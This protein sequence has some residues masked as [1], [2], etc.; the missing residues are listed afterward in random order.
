MARQVTSE[1][2]RASRSTYF[3]LFA[4]GIS[5]FFRSPTLF[6]SAM[7]VNDRDLPEKYRDSPALLPEAREKTAQSGPAPSREVPP[8]PPEEQKRK[9]EERGHTCGGDARR[10]RACRRPPASH[11]RRTPAR[12]LPLRK[13]QN[14]S[15]LRRGEV[16][17]GRKKPEAGRWNGGG[18][19]GGSP[20]YTYHSEDKNARGNRRVLPPTPAPRESWPHLGPHRP[21]PPTGSLSVRRLSASI[22]QNCCRGQSVDP[23]GGPQAGRQASLCKDTYPQR[24]RRRPLLIQYR[25]ERKREGCQVD[26]KSERER[27]MPRGS[28]TSSID[29]QRIRNRALFALFRPP[30]PRFCGKAGPRSSMGQLARVSAIM[31]TDGCSR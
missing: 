8:P 5:G 15:C 6:A 31:G 20:L 10:G 16:A 11:R 22:D 30:P 19:G 18:G 23:Q 2:I 3:L 26:R 14:L 21:P 1:R 24:S 17:D 29:V 12:V 27:E 7:L 9:E 28:P 13:G 4:S 25:G